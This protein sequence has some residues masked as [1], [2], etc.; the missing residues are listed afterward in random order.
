MNKA[1]PLSLLLAAVSLAGCVDTSSTKET[2]TSAVTGGDLTGTPARACRAAIA[3]KVGI[4]TADV[5]VFNVLDSEAGI[6]VE[7]TVATSTDPWRCYTD[8]SGHVSG[9]EFAG[10]EGA[11]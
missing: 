8:R 10:S 4:S 5:D 9:V 1:L 2:E 6:M 3:K 7:A 11:L